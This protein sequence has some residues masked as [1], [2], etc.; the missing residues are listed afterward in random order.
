M[1]L[2]SM[3]VAYSAMHFVHRAAVGALGRSTF[4]HVKVD[5]GVRVPLLHACQG[6]WAKDATLSVQVG[7]FE[8]NGFASSHGVILEDEAIAITKPL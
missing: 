3:R 5:L 6:R 4:G 8:F 1:H 2:V 7:G